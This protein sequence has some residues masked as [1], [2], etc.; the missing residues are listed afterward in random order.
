MNKQYSL[1]KVRIYPSMD[2]TVGATMPPK[3]DTSQCSTEIT[4]DYYR[5][6]IFQRKILA[7]ENNERINSHALAKAAIGNLGDKKAIA[8]FNAYEQKYLEAV[9]SGDVEASQRAI[10][11]IERLLKS[12]S[13]LGLSVA[14]ISHKSPRKRR[15]LG[16]ITSFGKRMVRSGA[17]ILESEYGRECLT[18]GTATLP[19]LTDEE[20]QAVCSSWAEVVRQFFQELTRELER[21]GVPTDYVHVTEIQEGRFERNGDVGLHLHWLSPGKASRYDH[22]ALAPHEFRDLWARILKNVIGRDVDCS[23]ATRVETPRSSLLQELGK[24]MSKGV[25]V[26]QSVIKAGKESQLPSAWWGA[27]KFLKSE[28]KTSIVEICGAA[29][30]WVDRHLR[31]LQDEDR[32]WYVDIWVEND[33]REFRAGAVGRF[34][35]RDD[36]DQ[37]LKFRDACLK[38]ASIA[39]IALYS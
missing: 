22:W 8:L 11:Q 14:T 10:D 27:S 9:K 3:R 4:E 25:S 13:L 15:G 39:E 35:S 2:F 30:L 32:I 18:F 19:A 6:G 7:V 23:A 38:S 26:I 33:G 37:L 36:C 29:A 12:R 1:L 24:Y 5:D 20:F 31:A 34:N 21:R 17:A 28:V 16:G